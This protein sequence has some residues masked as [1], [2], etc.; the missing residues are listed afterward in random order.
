VSKPSSRIRTNGAYV[1]KSAESRPYSVKTS[2]ASSGHSAI[3]TAG[4][5]K[6]AA[7]VRQRHNGRA[8]LTT[9]VRRRNS[10]ARA[11]S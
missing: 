1:I 8:P 3:V 6:L 7:A 11:L 5:K 10:G 2:G 9:V 4:D